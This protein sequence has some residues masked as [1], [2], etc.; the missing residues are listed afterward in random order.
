METLTILLF[1]RGLRVILP[2]AKHRSPVGNSPSQRVKIQENPG[3]GDEYPDTIRGD[4]Q[5]ASKAGESGMAARYALALFELADEQRK[6]DVVADDLK[7][8]DAAIEEN[9][10][11]RRMMASPVIGR[12]AQGQAIGEILKQAG[13]D[14]LTQRFVSVS[15]ANRRL[16]AIRDIIKAYLAELA[17]RR[18]E[19]TAEVTSAL[20]LSE[21]QTRAVEDALQR[22][23]GRNVALSL[24]VD[25]ALIGGMV[26]KVG[27]R[28]I[29]SSLKT[30]LDRM[31]LV[32][33]GAG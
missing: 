33:K 10:D 3:F 16:Y 7:A 17:K 24:K 1:R 2:C 18:G 9:E 15:A 19:V 8:L 12:D 30:Q 20:A 25:P 31:K 13:A 14:D 6:L 32:M 23:E 29:D 11:L 21:E 4:S 26:V 28:M 5:V 22:V 27:S